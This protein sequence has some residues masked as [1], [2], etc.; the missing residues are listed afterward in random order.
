M[1]QSPSDLTQS[2]LD[3]ARAAGADSADAMAT[4]GASLSID[5]LNG[6]LEHAERAENTDIGLRVMIG[7]RQACVSASDIKPDT[8]IT[9]AERAVAMAKQA[10]KDDTIGLADTSQLATDW[11]AEIL[12]LADPSPEPDPGDLKDRALR[13]EAAALDVD[14]ISQVPGAST[15]YSRHRIHLAASNGFSGGYERTSGGISCLAI[16]G[17]GTN[18]EQDYYYDGRVFQEDLETPEH[19]GNLAAQRTLQR[20]NACKPQTGSFPVLF[21]ERVSSSLIQHLL[22]AVN[23]SAIVRGSSWARDL[24]NSQVLPSALS[25]FENPHRA[26]VGGSRPFDGEGLATAPRTIV[27]NGTLTGWILDLATARKLDMTSTGNAVRGTSRPP[28]PSVSNVSLSQGTASQSDLIRDMGTGLLVTSLIGSSIN[29]TTGDY[30]RGAAG[31]WIEN[32]EISH[33]VNE[34]TI[35]GNLQNMLLSLIPANDARPHLSHVIPSLLVEG[36]TIAG[37]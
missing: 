26:R 24:L 1:A 35:A 9:M 15:G 28:S 31:Y 14:G 12:E 36:M 37:E 27:E 29:P 20:A 2:L 25:I 30:S 17:H 16:T 32:G 7:Q 4:E 6:Q 21:D 18:M 23:G 33:P 5:V 22:S 8:I 11:D 19:V 34:C 10:P 13:A 3:A